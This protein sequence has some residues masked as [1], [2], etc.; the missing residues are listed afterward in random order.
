MSVNYDELISIENLLESWRAYRKGK[1]KKRDVM[2]F[3]RHLEDNLFSL[4][5][6]LKSGSYAHNEYSYFRISDPKKRDI[7]KSTVRDRVVHQA[8][9]KYLCK[10]YE[11]LFTEYSFSSRK[12]KGTHKAVAALKK[13][14]SATKR[15]RKR[16]WAMKCDV[17]KYFE[18]IN[19]KI[20]SDILRS[21][22]SDERIFNLLKIIIES[23]H[24]ETARGVPL[25]NITSQI[26]ANVYLNELDKFAE[27]E[28]KF[29]NH[30]V[31]YNDDFIIIGD[32]KKN[33][34]NRVKKIRKFLSEKLMLELPQEKIT[35]RKLKWGID[36]CGCVILPNAVLL[37]NKT[38]GRMFGKINAIAHK[39]SLEK[40]SQSDFRRI[41]DSYLGLLSRCKA[42]NLRNK[43]K[44]RYCYVF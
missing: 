25:G 26:F 5:D 24:K 43:I 6:E 30:Y 44:N 38:K 11:P 34:F 21:Q 31:R 18:N 27:N 13:Q 16:C 12:G 8:L 20:L 2:E 32:N 9:Y 42:Y 33:L 35:F 41:I 3:E 7:Y 17:R 37:R 36:F 1:S 10:K 15:N 14:A 28:L 4:R 22:V 23:F 40:I 39:V 19:H 29:K